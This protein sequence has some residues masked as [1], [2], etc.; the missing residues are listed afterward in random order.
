MFCWIIWIG[1]ILY[2]ENICVKKKNFFFYIF[3][4]NPK[5]KQG[6][7]D[8]QRVAKDLIA[9]QKK[10]QEAHIYIYTVCILKQQQQ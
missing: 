8:T 5:D 7:F 9:K 10:I 1:G 3:F 6:R 4:K 2:E